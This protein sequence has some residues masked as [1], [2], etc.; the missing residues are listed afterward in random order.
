MAVE[1]STG[2]CDPEAAE[3]AV[4]TGRMQSWQRDYGLF[5]VSAM[6]SSGRTSTSPP[7]M[8]FVLSV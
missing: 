7:A 5:V 1:T 3:V 8:N 6:M 2:N 4:M